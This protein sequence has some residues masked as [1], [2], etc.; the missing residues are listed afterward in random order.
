MPGAT[1]NYAWP[2]QLL[3]DSP[4]GAALGH[5]G[6]IAADASLAAE[7]VLRL[8]AKGQ[9]IAQP[10][11]TGSGTIAASTN[12]VIGT[13]SIPDPG[14]AYHIIVSCGVGWTNPTGA[15]IGNMG[16]FLYAQVDSSVAN[17][18]IVTQSFAGNFTASSSTSFSTVCPSGNSRKLASTGYTGAH[19]LNMTAGALGATASIQTGLLYQLHI[20]IVAA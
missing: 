11:Q 4:N 8:A 14:Y 1:P 18:N 6:L 7:A 5:D 15:A 13:Y 20:Q 9:V 2:Y 10:T 3:S 17:T 16:V 19:T 12:A